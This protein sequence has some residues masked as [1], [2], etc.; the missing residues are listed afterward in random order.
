MADPITWGLI[1]LVKKGVKGVQTTLDGVSDKVSGLPDS[2]DADFT[3]VKNSVAGV[4]TDTSDIIAKIDAITDSINLIYTFANETNVI[5][6]DILL[7]SNIAEWIDDLAENG[8]SSTTYKDTSRMNTLLKSSDACKNNTVNDYLF[9]Y[10]YSNNLVGL[11][12]DTTSD[13][14]VDFSD[15]TS[16][17][18]L[19]NSDKVSAAF[20][21]ST[22]CK[23]MANNTN[24][25]I[26]MYNNYDLI[27][28]YER[29]LRSYISGKT[30]YQELGNIW[31]LGSGL[32]GRCY[33]TG[34]TVTNS[35]IATSYSDVYFETQRPN[36]ETT[37]GT[38]YINKGETKHVAYFG[39]FASKIKLSRITGTSA[40]YVY[41]DR[42]VF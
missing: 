9:R 26:D 20:N 22:V 27:K 3:E 19:L 6:K 15:I 32:S 10:A 35:Q 12:C 11:F 8:T 28:D 21:N 14:S 24:S 1:N 37:N 29:N 38:T 25:M 18:S 41:V 23:C 33:I 4:K 39:F 5:V 31:E 16:F 42:Y 17:S 7:G 2:L 36:G 34:M 13:G 40:N 30:S